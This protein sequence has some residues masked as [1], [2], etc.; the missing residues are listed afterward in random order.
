VLPD[1]DAG[2]FGVL[3]AADVDRPRGARGAED[4]PDQGRTKKRRGGGAR[5]DGGPA[6]SGGSSNSAL[7]PEDEWCYVVTEIA[8]AFGQDW[9][10]IYNCE[11]H[12]KPHLVWY[13]FYHLDDARRID[14]LR[15]EI[16]D[17]DRAVL[18]AFAV[19]DP[20][21]FETRRKELKAK[22]RGAAGAPAKPKWTHEEMR[23]AA[24]RLVTSVINTGKLP[25]K[26]IQ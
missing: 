13:C 17:Y 2:R 10:R 11:P 9:F 26:V 12:G 24:Q 7:V 14:E 6:S 22:L 8:R 1:R 25:P 15:R 21:G 3:H 4:R 23:E 20:K 18:T 16:D 5:G 19:N